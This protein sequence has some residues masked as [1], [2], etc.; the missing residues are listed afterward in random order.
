[1]EDSM[2]NIIVTIIFLLTSVA[3]NEVVAKTNKCIQCQN[4]CA[5]KYPP[6]SDSDQYGNCK[7]MC[8]GS[9]VCLGRNYSQKE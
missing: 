1:M 5:K 2:R 8:K 7:L 4:R 3:A 9:S 6:V